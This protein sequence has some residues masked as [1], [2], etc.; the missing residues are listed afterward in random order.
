MIQEIT[1]RRETI[2]L[3]HKME[4]SVYTQMYATKAVIIQYVIKVKDVNI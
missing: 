4:K 3:T 1:A 2:F